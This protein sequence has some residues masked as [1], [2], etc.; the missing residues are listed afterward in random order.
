MSQ[1]AVRQPTSAA[2]V[3]EPKNFGKR[4]EATLI[5]ITRN[6][7]E[8]HF[9]VSP[10]ATGMIVGILA[11]FAV[12]YFSA[13]AYLM[14]RDDLIGMTQAR[15]AR[16]LHEYEDRIASLRSNLDRV[17][18][19]QLLDQQAI[20]A[21]VAQ[22]MERQEALG[23]RD[24]RIGKLI[25]NAQK[26]GLQTKTPDISSVDPVATGSVVT[27][28]DDKPALER[29]AGLS[30]FDLRGSSG[31]LG[32]PSQPVLVVAANMPDISNYNETRDLFQ[33]VKN[34]IEQVDRSQ[35]D[36]L[37]TLRKQAVERSYKIATVLDQLGAKSAKD[38]SGVGGPYIALDPGTAFEA[39]VEAL[40]QSLKS[41]DKANTLLSRLPVGNPAKGAPL[42][43]PFGARTDPFLG[44]AAMHSGLDFKASTGTEVRAAADGKV[45]DAG[46]NGGYGNMVEIDHGNGIAT[47]YAHLSKI[48][49]STGDKITRGT[50]IGEVGSTGRSTGPHLH[51]EVRKH[52]KAVDPIRYLKA[53]RSI[54]NLL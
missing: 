15:N 21:E 8:R 43:S 24:G 3:R 1:S 31:A 20:E 28:A 41:L 19:R 42:S 35:R 4:R 53:G 29:R 25:E 5:T 12:G 18:S 6:G 51:Y 36:M 14:L 34:R 45:I 7:H 27:P 48:K 2:N 17:T 32:E 9:P 52:G 44:H 13:T 16:L 26:R 40:D 30:G 37:D 10:L 47:R 33:S 50:V 49:V 39:H 23:G 54:S 22:L 11:M 46:R 38:G